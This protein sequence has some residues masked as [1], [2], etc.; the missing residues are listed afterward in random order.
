MKKIL[1]F[2]I[3]VLCFSSSSQADDVKDFKIEGMGLTDSLLLFSSK[4]IIEKNKIF[5]PGKKYYRVPL[6]WDENNNYPRSNQYNVIFGVTKYEDKE[7]IIESLEAFKDF[8]NNISGCLSKKKKITDEIIKLFPN[9]KEPANSV[10]NSRYRGGKAKV[11]LSIFHLEKG[12]IQISCFEHSEDAKK[13]GK[14]DVLAV[15]IYSL[16]FDKYLA[17]IQ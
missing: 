10:T 8:D 16:E 1:F 3:L 11:H 9:S 13:N 5:Y 4:E 15:A 17:S 7:Y 6:F 12:K 2:I 14:S